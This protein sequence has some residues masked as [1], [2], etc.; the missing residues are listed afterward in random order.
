[1]NGDGMTTSA[2]TLSVLYLFDAAAFWTIIWRHDCIQ[3]LWH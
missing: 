3:L 2:L 1:M